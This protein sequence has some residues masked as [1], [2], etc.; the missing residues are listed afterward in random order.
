MG[1][2]LSPRVGFALVFDY[3]ATGEDGNVFHAEHTD[4]PRFSGESSNGFSL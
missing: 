2:H 3:T 4:C 1:I